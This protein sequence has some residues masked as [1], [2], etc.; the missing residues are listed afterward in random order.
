VRD[1]PGEN[2]AGKNIWSFKRDSDRGYM[3]PSGVKATLHREL[4]NR[5][6]EKIT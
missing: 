4:K 1:G 6:V 5:G 3:G 2:G